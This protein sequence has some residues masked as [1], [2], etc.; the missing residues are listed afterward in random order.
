MLG[1][2][3]TNLTNVI[4]AANYDFGH[5][6]STGGGGVASL[7]SVCSANSKAR[8]VTGRTVSLIGMLGARP[9]LFEFK[10]AP[11]VRIRCVLPDDHTPLLLREVEVSYAALGSRGELKVERLM[12]GVI[13]VPPTTCLID[14]VFRIGT[15][16]EWDVEDC[17]DGTSPVGPKDDFMIVYAQVLG[18]TDI[19]QA[20]DREIGGAPNA[21]HFVGANYTCR[22]S[23]LGMLTRYQDAK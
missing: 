14:A 12:L 1:Q 4:G 19:A 11:R 5:V 18:M 15:G 3:Q 9:H 22:V 20:L 2:N 7:N 17:L 23:V 8:G 10:I 6:F 21:R 13:Q 16:H